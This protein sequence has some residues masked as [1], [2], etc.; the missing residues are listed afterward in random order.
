[1]KSNP[2]RLGE[3]ISIVKKYQLTKNMTPEKVR[4]ALEELGPTFVK[5]GQILSSRDDLIPKKYCQEL[6]KLKHAVKPM[7]YEKVEEIISNIHKKDI[8]EIIKMSEIIYKSK[9]II[10]DILENI[11]IQLMEL[12]KNSYAYLE[13]IDIVENTKKRLKMNAN[14]D[15]CIDNMLLQMKEKLNI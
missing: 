12:S 6:Q 8:I 5:M 3:I 1:M 14:Y 7:S 2:S 9:E 15:M 13:C 4:M 11:N 10:N